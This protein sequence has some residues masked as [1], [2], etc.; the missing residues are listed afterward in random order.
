VQRYNNF[1]RYARVLGEN[2][3]GD[4]RRRGSD[5]FVGAKV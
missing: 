3:M 5:L 4:L 1:F 2:L